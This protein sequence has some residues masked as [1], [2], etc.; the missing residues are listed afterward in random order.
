MSKALHLLAISILYKPNITNAIS[1]YHILVQNMKILPNFEP[2]LI[3][4]NLCIFPQLDSLIPGAFYINV[5]DITSLKR[6]ETMSL[7]L[8]ES[9][10]GHHLQ[11]TF[12]KYSDTPN[13]LKVSFHTK[14]NIF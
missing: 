9:N 10:P 11:E 1:A 8:H 12:A 13:F 3:H 6:Y 2:L 5:D 7:T 4:P 14:H